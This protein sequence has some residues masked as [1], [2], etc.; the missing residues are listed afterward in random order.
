MNHPII[1]PRVAELIFRMY[2][3]P[4]HPELVESLAKSNEQLASAVQVFRTRAA[5]SFRIAVVLAVAL[6][7]LLWRS[8]SN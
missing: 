8:L 4:L 2:D 5:W 1:R 3:R 6:A 7:W